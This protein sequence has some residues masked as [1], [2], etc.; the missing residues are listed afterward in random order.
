MKKSKSLWFI[1]SAVLFL[2][3]F[4]APAQEFKYETVPGDP[5]NTR[6]YTLDNGLKVYMSVYKDEPRIQTYVAVRVGG[7]ND[8]KETTGLAHYFEHMMFKG[9]PNFGTLDWE[10]ESA[11]IN[12]V[13]S[14]FEIYRVE[15]DNDKRAAIY[16]VIDSISFEA[17]KLA[18]PNE[19]DKLM[20]A[21][22]A[23]GTNAGTSYDYTVYIENIPS[24]Q[25]D[26][27][28]AIQAD[29]FNQPVLRLFHTELETVYEEKNMSLTNDGRK[30]SEALLKSLLPNHPYGQQTVLGEAEHLK[31]PSMKNIR[32]FYQRYYIP[33]NMAVVMAG[34]FNPDEAIKVVAQHFGKLKA[35]ELPEFKYEK[36]TPITQPV[37]SEVTG[38]EAENV[39]LAYRFKGANSNEALMADM[40]SMM[41]ANGKAGLIDLNINKKQ[42]TLGSGAY[43]MKLTDYSILQLYG[44]NKNG[45]TLEEVKDLLL[46]QIELLKKGEFPDWMLEAAINNLKLREMK[47][48]ESSNGRARVMYM[49]YLNN[50]EWKDAINQINEYGKITKADL[51]KF[52]NEHLN[53]NYV[54]VYK[55]KGNP[56]EI[57]K[58]QKPAITPIHINRNAESD[59]LK[60]IK[61]KTVTPIEPVFID[62]E[63]D[64]TKLALN[65][66]IEILYKQ[67]T[68][69]NTF[70]LA[71]YLPFG[72][73]SDP[74]INLAAQYLQLI[75]T[76]KLSAEEVSQEFYKMACSYSVYPGEDETYVL[77]SGLS[78]NAPKAIELFESLLNDGKADQDALNSMV[79]NILKSREDNKLS[80]RNVFAGLVS[81]ATYGEQSTFT[82]IVSEEQLK[83][84]K[85]EELIA[86][87]KQFT[88]YPHK[89]IY[90]GPDKAADFKKAITKY[91]KVPKKTLEIPAEKSFEPLETPSN[92]VLFTDYDAKQSYLQTVTK[93]G[94]YNASLLPTIRMYNNYFGGGMN[95]IVFQE[96]REKR[97]LAYTARATYSIPN[98]TAKPFMNNSFIAT[99]NDKVIDAFNAFNELFTDMPESETAFNLAKQSIL[100][101]IRTERITK[102]DIIW[103]YL[104]AQKMGRKED[105]RKTYFQTIPNITLADIKKFQQEYV[106]GKPK[107]YVILGKESDFNFEEIE[108]LYGPV[109]KVSREQIFGY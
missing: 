17:S 70:T 86:K 23:T 58:V 26:N 10:G 82:N 55:R 30:A 81:Y 104:D 31:N 64:I 34:D 107:T 94:P 33:N 63:K 65:K 85:A 57:A 5:L 101:D 27:W 90:Y 28:A 106:K 69:N 15:T 38:L 73:N 7:K 40:L 67:N 52:A 84:L 56:E 54:V 39:L 42:L 87:I 19:Y 103:S 61:A 51:V 75:G 48:Y 60:N 16:H 108:K 2:L 100:S 9:T 46:S 24:N 109:T 76:S 13:D 8:P 44:R 74:S 62:Y 25:I 77:L 89:V 45:Q 35:K 96:M 78:E 59:F 102:L 97:S 92:R 80:Q 3:S 79:A 20:S 98:S 93:G 32:E 36:E 14:L 91:H 88:A 37:V 6:I 47:M 83:L 41:L 50:I 66:N 4:N 12:K 68:E 1:L 105:I 53:N 22:G 71:Y 72:S 99:Q 49:S 11:L 95:A 29:R 43:N 21:I 18:I